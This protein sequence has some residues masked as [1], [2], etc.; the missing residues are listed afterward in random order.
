MFN[1]NKI[2]KIELFFLGKF[3]IPIALTFNHFFFGNIEN[4]DVNIKKILTA[5]CIAF[6]LNWFFYE[7]IMMWSARIGQKLRKEKKERKEREEKK[8]KKKAHNT[9]YEK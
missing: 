9:V 7:P 5:F 1:K 3:A 4:E 2:R 6:T 8:G